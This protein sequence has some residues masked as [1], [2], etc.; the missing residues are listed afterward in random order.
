[1]PSNPFSTFAIVLIL[2]TLVSITGCNTDLDINAPYREFTVIYAAFNQDESTHLVKINKSFL[3]EGNALDFAQVQDSSEY[4]NDELVAMVHKIENGNVTDTYLLRDTVIT[5]RVPGTFYFPEQ[6]LY[7]F[8]AILDENATYEVEARVRDQI[9]RGRTNIV[10]RFRVDQSTSSPSVPLSLFNPNTNSYISDEVE[11]DSGVDGKR[12][13]VSYRFKWREVIGTDTTDK[14]FT[15][16]LGQRRFNQY[17][18]WAK[19][20][21]A[22]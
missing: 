7:S 19:P 10:N 3:G 15:R 11:W 13:V 1:M 16:S 20:S 2:A 18:R 9:F 5:N 17:H 14:S 21:S 22:H 12:Y 4:T 8:Q 6:T